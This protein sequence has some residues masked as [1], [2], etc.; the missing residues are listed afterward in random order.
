MSF[1]KEFKEFA[2]KGNVMDLAIGVVIGAAFGK[3][4]TS[5]V[6]DIVMP[7]ITLITG[8]IN[9]EDHFINLDPSKGTPITLEAANAAGVPTLKY[10]LFITNIV[11][12]LIIALVIFIVV[13][14][15]NRFR[16]KPVPAAVTTK[17]CPYCHTSIHI[18]ATRCPHCTSDLK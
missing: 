14:Q 7:V 5:L 15:I 10:G 16:P 6:N 8:K 12:F 9:F 18:D 1:L 3:I 4:V 17:D 13:K 11:D 2:M